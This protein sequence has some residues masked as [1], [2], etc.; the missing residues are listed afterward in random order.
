MSPAVGPG[1][2]FHASYTRQYYQYDHLHPVLYNKIVQAGNDAQQEVYPYTGSLKNFTG[3]DT[4]T[5]LI[6][7]Q[8]CST[9]KTSHIDGD[10]IVCKMEKVDS[11]CP[12]GFFNIPHFDNVDKL[13]EKEY[14]HWLEAMEKKK[15]ELV[16]TQKIKNMVAK[17]GMGMPTIC[18]YNIINSGDDKAVCAWF[19][20]IFFCAPIVNGSLH[21]FCAWAF[22]HCTCVPFVMDQEKVITMNDG[23]P[24]DVFIAGWGKGAGKEHAKK[25]RDQST[26]RRR[27]RR[28]AQGI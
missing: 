4:C 10:A 18:G 21:Y 28:R 16:E 1:T 20:E 23:G 13:T 6:W 26:T 7:T 5:R 19:A 2:V 27:S 17:I 14:M 9:R 24:N 15:S 25:E 22:A 12:K 3:Y 8:G 11:V